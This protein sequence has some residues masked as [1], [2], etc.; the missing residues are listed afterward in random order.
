MGPWRPGV[1]WWCLPALL[2]AVE[3]A[4]WRSWG[5]LSSCL[6]PWSECS[7][8]SSPV[9]EFWLPGLTLPVWLFVRRKPDIKKSQC[10]TI[11]MINPKTVLT[12]NMSL[13]PRPLLAE[14]S[15]YVKPCSS[16]QS[17]ASTSSTSLKWEEKVSEVS[18]VTGGWWRPL[19][20]VALVGCQETHCAVQTSSFSDQ[21]NMFAMTSDGDTRQFSHLLL[22]LQYPVWEI[23]KWFP[24]GDVHHHQETVGL[25]VEL[26]SH[27]G[28]QRSSWRVENMN[29]NLKTKWKYLCGMSKVYINTSLLS[30]YI[31][32]AP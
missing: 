11:V 22:D 25:T 9:W 23:L 16:A 15:K 29:G 8:V 32:V 5:S 1:F 2:R 30:T 10:Y 20:G 18:K 26:I 28:K 4:G 21:L 6:S 14:V 31:L 12:W 17:L 19:T 27:I 3:E 13:T 24:P 7:Q